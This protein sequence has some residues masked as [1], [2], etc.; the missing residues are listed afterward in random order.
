MSR[1]I[2]A[3]AAAALWACA[4]APKRD[5]AVTANP[6]EEKTAAVRTPPPEAKGRVDLRAML[7]REL[8]KPLHVRAVKFPEGTFTGQT[9]AAGD[10]VV[11]RHQGFERVQ[12]PLGLGAALDC[13]AY[14]QMI[15]AAGSLQLI[16]NDAAQRVTMRQVRPVDVVAI[17]VNPLLFAEAAYTTKTPA[18]D[19]LGLIKM[20]VFSTPDASLMCLHDELGYS[21]TFQR[22]LTA[23]ARSFKPVQPPE[24]TA[25]FTALAV[26]KLGGHPIGFERHRIH[27]AADGG[28]VDEIVEAMLMPRSQSE[29]LAKDSTTVA[30][31]DPAGRVSAIDVV[32]GENGEVEL[33]MSV[34]RTRGNKY[35]YEGV[36]SGK[37]VKGEFASSDPSG[38]PGEGTVETFVRTRL[39]DGKTQDYKLEH[40]EPSIDF[41]KPVEL[42]LKPRKEGERAVTIVIGNLEMSGVADAQGMVER[43]EAAM[44]PTTFSQRRV[45]TEG[46]P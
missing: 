39:F 6:P 5:A 40:Y 1:F 18:G 41:S 43:V 15:D 44:G 42:L 17:G 36:R 26:V 3:V 23:F 2:I 16:L 34:K 29:I 46:T 28:R 10:A 30:V 8:E 20:G 25:R 21:K 27:D 22:M 4:A 38:L 13:Y 14:P 9:E 45:A 19:A 37:K 35:S 31:S 12:V 7:A 24:T 33:Q 11:E 32:E